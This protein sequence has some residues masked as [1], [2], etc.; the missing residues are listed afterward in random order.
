MDRGYNSIIKTNDIKKGQRVEFRDGR[1]GVMMDNKRG[2]IRCVRVD[3]PYPEMGDVYAHDL[4]KAET[5]DGWG[6][7]ALTKAQT[8]LRIKVANIGGW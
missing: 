8:E 1:T 7:V 3:G 2:N 4:Y 5:P 6:V